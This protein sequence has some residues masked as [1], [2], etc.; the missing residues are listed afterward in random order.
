MTVC[1]RE[2]K[3]AQYPWLHL[4]NL[5]GRL[6]VFVGEVTEFSVIVAVDIINSDRRVKWRNF[7]TRL[8]YFTYDCS[9]RV[10][11]PRGRVSVA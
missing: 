10:T 9:R 7:A 5:F 8:P 6:S 4:R 3:S 1:A 2:L 11:I